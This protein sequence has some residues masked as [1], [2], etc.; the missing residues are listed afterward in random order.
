LKAFHGKHRVS[1]LKVQRD[2]Y[3]AIEIVMQRSQ[4]RSRR[5]DDNPKKRLNEV[6]DHVLHS[7]EEGFMSETKKHSKGKQDVSN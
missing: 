4:T 7:Q 5:E 1:N 3:T 2:Y 6:D